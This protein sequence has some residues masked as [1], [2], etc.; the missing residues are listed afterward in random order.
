[1]RAGT[2]ERN[3]TTVETTVGLRV[4]RRPQ[5]HSRSTIFLFERSAIHAQL[6]CDKLSAKR[7]HDAGARA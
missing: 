3:E 5:Q 4:N 2:G 1:M 7:L 6:R